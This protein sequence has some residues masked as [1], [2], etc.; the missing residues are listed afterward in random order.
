METHFNTV[1]PKI[2]VF[3]CAKILNCV[4][5]VAAAKNKVRKSTL[6][7]SWRNIWP[8]VVLGKNLVV[9][10]IDDQYQHVINLAKSDKGEGFKDMTVEEIKELTVE[11][12]LNEADLIDFLSDANTTSEDADDDNQE[13]EDLNKASSSSSN[14]KALHAHLDMLAKGANFL[15]KI[16]PLP[17]LRQKFHSLNNQKQPLITQFVQKC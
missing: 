5:I 9:P 14:S 1:F 17:D 7:G 13:T 3:F 2:W 11:S 16:D 6:N 4:E 12:K 10:S 15:R 8:I